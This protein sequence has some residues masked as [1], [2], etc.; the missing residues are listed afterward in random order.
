MPR[1]MSAIF[2]LFVLS[3]LTGQRLIKAEENTCGT[4][5]NYTIKPKT[6]YHEA[7]KDGRLIFKNEK[8]EDLA[9]RLE[10][11]FGVKIII[12]NPKI[13]EVKITGLFEN[14]TIVQVLEALK[15]AV[16]FE[17]KINDKEIL[18]Y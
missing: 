11:W 17:Y 3:V 8:F 6:V 15:I 9:V 2:V 18:I 14:E 13:K 12:L 7:W 16:P 10:K 4:M 1:L 5:I